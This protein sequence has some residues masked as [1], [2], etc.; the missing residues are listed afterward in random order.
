MRDPCNSQTAEKQ[1]KAG[2]RLTLP[3]LGANCRVR[4][5]GRFP[6]YNKQHKIATEIKAGY[7]HMAECVNELLT[8]RLY[9]S[10]RTPWTYC[11]PGYRIIGTVYRGMEFGLLA[12]AEAGGYVRAN[13]FLI[14]PLDRGEVDAAIR[15]FYSRL[16]ARPVEQSVEPIV[17][18]RKSRRIPAVKGTTR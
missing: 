17:T 3:V 10:V 4:S 13:G 9:R 16:A 18:V 11:Q 15:A 12:I 7:V 8:V 1:R 14:Q 5:R 6:E 2:H